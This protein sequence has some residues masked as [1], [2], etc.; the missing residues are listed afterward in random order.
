MRHV[1]GRVDVDEE[2]DAGDDREHDQGEVVDR[3]GEVDVEAGDGDPG[4]AGDGEELGCAGGYHG[5]PEPGDDD[6]GDRGEEQRDGG[7]GGARQ[8]AADGSVDQE[9]GEGKQRDE[10]EKVSRH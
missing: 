9:A 8:P 10:P 6:G 1:A 5:A 2:A 4:A 3:E 7:D